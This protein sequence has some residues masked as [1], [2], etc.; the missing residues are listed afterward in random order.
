MQIVT[1]ANW[2]DRHIP[3]YEKQ[4]QIQQHAVDP[5]VSILVIDP[6]DRNRRAAGASF[7]WSTWEATDNHINSLG[8]QVEPVFLDTDTHQRWYWAFWSADEALIT[9]LK[10]S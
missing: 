4:K 2:L 7:A 8:Y 1:W 3:Y 5:P 9:V 6:V 10:L